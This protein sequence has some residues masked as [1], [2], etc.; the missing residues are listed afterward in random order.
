MPI[1]GT[2][3]IKEKQLLEDDGAGN[4]NTILSSNSNVYINNAMDNYLLI[5]QYHAYSGRQQGK[6]TFYKLDS[7]SKLNYLGYSQYGNRFSVDSVDTSNN[8]IYIN[9]RQGSQL[10][11][12]KLTDTAGLGLEEI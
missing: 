11:K 8:I 1:N 4:I 6:R 3:F 2:A 10:K 7:N 9:Y 5:S 12:Y